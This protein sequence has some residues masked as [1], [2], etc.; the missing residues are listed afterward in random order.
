[1]SQYRA[2]DGYA[3]DWHLVHLG[4]FALGGAALVYVEATAVAKEGRRTHGDLG[5]WDDAHIEGLR[6]ITRFLEQEVTDD[7]VRLQMSE[8]LKLYRNL[9]AK[10]WEDE[11]VSEDDGGSIST[12]ERQLEQLAEDARLEA[13]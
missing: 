8:T 10:C 5:I 13:R 2:A 11:A 6:K 12:L 4:R 1:M 7:S 3:N 9:I